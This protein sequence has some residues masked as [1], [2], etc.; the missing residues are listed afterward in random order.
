MKR[1]RLGLL[2]AFLAAPLFASD[3][4]ADFHDAPIE[5][6]FVETV[7]VQPS[8][9]KL[10][11][12]ADFALDSYRTLLGTQTVRGL[13]TRAQPSL[14]YRYAP[15][16]AAEIFF[17]LPYTAQNVEL[18]DA[19]GSRLFSQYSAGAGQ[20]SVGFKLP[21]ASWVA[22]EGRTDLPT[23]ALDRTPRL[24]DGAHYGGDLLFRSGRWHFQAGHTVR[25]PYEIQ[26]A[27]ETFRRRPGGVTELALARTSQDI[28]TSKT[29]Y[30]GT[31]FELHGVYT[32]RE[33]LDG[34]S[35][36]DSASLAGRAVFGFVLGKINLRATHLTQVAV[37]V[38]FGDG[39]HKTM[40]P[41]FGVGDLHLTIGYTL[42]WGS[43]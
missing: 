22:V 18:N 13:M 12:R 26:G 29:D 27:T 4:P 34:E 16:G 7:S 35:L 6:F 30:V 9:H 38:G 15:G 43:H 2:A 41:M 25:L 3:K 23:E 20:P 24:G 21:F 5:P 11:V 33:R 8:R 37:S 28:H 14:E 40:D 31:V 1:A 10:S 39:L 42:L 17:R 19:D 32:D 36:K